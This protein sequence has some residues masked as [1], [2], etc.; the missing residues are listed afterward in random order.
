MAKAKDG[1]TRETRSF[2]YQVALFCLRTAGKQG[3]IKFDKI[4]KAIAAK[5]NGI[6]VKEKTMVCRKCKK[7]N[8]SGSTFCRFCGIK[9]IPGKCMRCEAPCP[10][11]AM[12]CTACGNPVDLD[13]LR[14]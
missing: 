5:N 6:T 14:A 4:G 3:A 9:L 13:K 11:D 7:E 2:I 1:I 12:H 8:D 10:P